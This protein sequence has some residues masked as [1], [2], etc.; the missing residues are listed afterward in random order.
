MG[1]GTSKPVPTTITRER[2]LKTTGK[3]REIIDIIFDFMIQ[4]I[5]LR[6]FYSLSSPERC[7]R[8]VLFMANELYSKFIE[9]RI[10][11]TLDKSGSIMFRKV[12]DLTNP[13][14]PEKR[15]QQSICLHLAFF[16]VRIFQIYGAL[17]LT[18]LDDATYSQTSGVFGLAKTRDGILPPPGSI[19]Y[20]ASTSIQLPQR[21]EIPLRVPEMTGG[22][23]Y[24]SGR[25]IPLREEDKRSLRLFSPFA[26]I[27]RKPMFLDTGDLATP[28]FFIEFSGMHKET[29][30]P[31]CTF[32]KMD[33]SHAIIKCKLPN[34]SY[35]IEFTARQT[36]KGTIRMDIDD[37]VTVKRR[38]EEETTESLSELVGS[39]K[40][41]ALHF[42]PHFTEWRVTYIHH[43]TPESVTTFMYNLLYKLW[44]QLA[45]SAPVKR[46]V[47]DRDGE[48]SR[49]GD[50]S[51][52]GN[53]S[54]LFSEI[55]GTNP[56]LHLEPIIEGL[57]RKRKFAHCVGRA[58]QLLDAVPQ[59]TATVG[60]KRVSYVCNPRF[61][62]DSISGSAGTTLSKATGIMALAD[63]F[64]DTVKPNMTSV[65]IGDGATMDEYIDF[66]KRMTKVFTGDERQLNAISE[67]PDA[68][69]RSLQHLETTDR[70]RRLCKGQYDT[71]VIISNKSIQD[72]VYAI[73]QHLFYYQIVHASR[74]ADILTQLFEIRQDKGQYSIRIHPNIIK[75]GIAEIDRIS[76]VTR[77][78]LV[79][80]YERC[81]TM[82]VAGMK[83]ILGS[84]SEM[85]VQQVLGQ[86]KRSAILPPG[87]SAVSSEPTVEDDASAVPTVP[88]A[89]NTILRQAR[90]V[91]N[92][93]R[94]VRFVNSD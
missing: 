55:G 64:Y 29:G 53:A 14:E 43:T 24:E 9:F 80:Y 79:D 20:L 47:Y 38:G 76:R 90:M 21:R 36:D 83:T 67:N 27:L 56:R 31:D 60:S 11:P 18:L 58:L 92:K 63:L 40:I 17:A 44:Q 10:Y 94:K 26:S 75:R 16:Y 69:L 33:D 50:G 48:N 93:T 89:K 5:Q 37:D 4:N 34:M 28:E 82:Y 15:R 12:D 65:S 32:K 87:A 13:P 73:V 70:D 35:T 68:Q 1:G 74:C 81:E 46:E 3:T 45:S 42:T 86:A 71:N 61:S 49:R 62:K 6:D 19:P 30:S 8:Y 85:A 72:K 25:Y 54:K 39:N 51:R 91:A 22:G 2:L 41:L 88:S 23:L 57:T 84:D 7:R 66:M 77:S 78:L 59:F 52:P